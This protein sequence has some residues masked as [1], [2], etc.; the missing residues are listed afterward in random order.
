MWG[1]DRATLAVRWFF[2]QTK[3]Y[4]RKQYLFTTLNL[5]LSPVFPPCFLRHILD[6]QR[7]YFSHSESIS[8]A[9]SSVLNP[10][11]LL[12]E[13]RQSHPH[14]LCD[15]FDYLDS[16]GFW[17]RKAFYALKIPNSDPRA[18]GKLLLGKPLPL[19]QLTNSSRDPKL[20]ILCHEKI[21]WP[22]RFVDHD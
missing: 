8:H 11:K 6:F 17:F 19:P 13:F 14:G 9:R 12:E 2:D 4:L 5:F 22:T 7:L 15:S 10:K 16:R 18:L 21:L 3:F 1:I 20:N